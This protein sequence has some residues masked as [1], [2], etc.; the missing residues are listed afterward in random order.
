MVAD[1]IRSHTITT[2]YIGVVLIVAL[3]THSV[4]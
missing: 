1:W 3:V 4:T 2:T